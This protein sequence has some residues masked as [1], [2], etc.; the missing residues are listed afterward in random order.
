MLAIK[1]RQM[2]GDKKG[3]IPSKT[4][5]NPMAAIRVDQLKLP[6]NHMQQGLRKDV[7]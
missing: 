7:C 5:S 4:N 6:P 1:R 2:N 3:N